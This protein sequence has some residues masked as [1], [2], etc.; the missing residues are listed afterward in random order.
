MPVILNQTL[1]HLFGDSDPIGEEIAVG[2]E[3]PR[4]L[5]VVGVATPAVGR[6]FGP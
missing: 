6:Q 1:A 2:R 3:K 5:Q 4:L